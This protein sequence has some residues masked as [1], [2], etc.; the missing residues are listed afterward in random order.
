M[1]TLSSGSTTEAVIGYVRVSTAEQADSGAGLA[2]QRAA[3]VA[4]CAR[5]GWQLVQWKGN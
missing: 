1:S 2:A 5:R 3:I 4:E